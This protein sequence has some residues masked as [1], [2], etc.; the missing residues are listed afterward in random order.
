MLVHGHALAELDVDPAA[1]V[2]QKAK[3][4]ERRDRRIRSRSRFR[5]G[6]PALLR[7]LGV[8][9]RGTLPP[10]ET[11]SAEPGM[12]NRGAGPAAGGGL[13]FWADSGEDTPTA[14]SK[15]VN[16]R[17][18]RP[19]NSIAQIRPRFDCERQIRAEVLL[20]APPLS[21]GSTTTCREWPP[22][23]R[24]SP[25]LSRRKSRAPGRRDPWQS[26]RSAGLRCRQRELVHLGGDHD[27]GGS[28]RVTFSCVALTNSM[29]SR[30]SC[31]HTAPNVDH[32]H[33]AAQRDARRE[34]AFDEHAPLRLLVLARAWRIRTPADRRAPSRGLGRLDLKQVELPGGPRGRPGAHQALSPDR[35]C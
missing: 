26:A 18:R 20:G 14:T 6:T 30:S 7:F 19:E 4:R 10:R 21:P 13:V 15:L 16:A 25:H 27:D 22:R 29:S 3:T 12:A 1:P 5:F 8:G 23:A 35:A 11:E 32:E 31:F 2:R 28:G 33:H 34:V 24:P 9:G 17:S